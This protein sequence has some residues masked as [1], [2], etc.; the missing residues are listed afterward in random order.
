MNDDV[1]EA[2][3]NS[4]KLQEKINF[5]IWP[6]F[7]RLYVHVRIDDISENDFGDYFC[8]IACLTPRDKQFVRYERFG[9]F[10]IIPY[11]WR[12]DIITH[13]FSSKHWMKTAFDTSYQY[14]EFVDNAT[15]VLSNLR[16]IN[17]QLA[18]ALMF[19]GIIMIVSF[20]TF[21]LVRIVNDLRRKQDMCLV[22][23][24]INTVNVNTGDRAIKYDVFLSYSSTDRAWVLQLYEFLKANNYTVCLDVFD[25]PYGCSLPT[26]IAEAVT[27]S[28]K[29]IAVISPAYV[30]SG[31]T[32]YELVISLTQI[33]DRQAP[34]DSLLPIRYKDCVMP[35][36]L[37]TWIKYVD[38]AGMHEDINQ[39]TL[40]ERLIRFVFHH[41]RQLPTDESIER[42]F[43]DKILSYLGEPSAKLSDKKDD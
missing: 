42:R 22:G 36:H 8:L 37:A 24:V 6:N 13:S 3:N 28:R 29:I 31:W 39:P 33:I 25:F 18:Y 11:S 40:F 15:S 34:R 16:N 5:E 27:S 1:V 38:Y 32:E 30:A 23:S 35:V 14:H 43:H 17:N 12:S 2:L 19:V 41:N 10:S 7:V 20:A 21:I 26:K 9:N 4:H